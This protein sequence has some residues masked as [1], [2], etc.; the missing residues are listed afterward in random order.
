L[1]DE[2]HRRAAIVAGLWAGLLINTKTVFVLS[3][4]GAA[5][6]LAL[7]WRPRYTILRRLVGWS[8]VGLAPGV[9]ATLVYNHARWGTPF[10][11]GYEAVTRGFFT[12]NVFFGLWGQF[13]SPGKSLFLYAPPILIG[14][15][16]FR[17][18]ARRRPLATLALA[19]TTTPLVLFYSR[20]LFWSG[21][22][23]WGPRY[24]VFACPVLALPLAE[25]LG[26]M[27]VAGA[28]RARL[29][30][31]VTIAFGVA[32]QIL[33]NAF[34]WDDYIRLSTW[35]QRA[36]LGQPDTRGTPVAPHPCMSCFEHV[37]PIQWLPPMAPI[38]G[39]LWLLRN[40]AA[41]KPWQAAA[42]DAPWGR[43]TSLALDIR[44]PYEASEI[45]W[46][47]LAFRK[48]S[49]AAVATTGLLMAFAVP[50]ARCVRRLRAS[51]DA[52]P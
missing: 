45:D 41:G 23:A 50:L 40:R 29:A 7:A 38:R 32:V 11:T 18:L 44:Y 20:Y 2:P 17:V 34:Y 28:G 8:L 21:D 37:Y 42:A 1:A 12:E 30:M 3:L 16:G 47:P 24:L 48:R 22:W 10:A 51:R 6:F 14:L 49:G 19:L 36:W 26:R 39:H 15:W 35:A 46:W 9:G 52:P 33:G 27:R 4:P 13:F 31:I 5:L 43:Y 25:V